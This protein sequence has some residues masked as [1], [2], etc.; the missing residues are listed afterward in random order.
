[1][2][3]EINLENKWVKLAIKGAAT[4][5]GFA[6]SSVVGGLCDTFIDTKDGLLKSCLEIGKFGIET[7]VLYDVATTMNNE[8][9]ETVEAYNTLASEVNAGREAMKSDSQTVYISKEVDNG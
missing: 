1:M 5:I 7:V 9:N 4:L 3:V 2:L 6:A 8:I